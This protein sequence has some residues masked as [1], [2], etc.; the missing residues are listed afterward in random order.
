M[1]FL[2]VMLGVFIG[3]GAVAAVQGVMAIK[4]RRRIRPNVFERPLMDVVDPKNED[5]MS[6]LLGRIRL[7]YGFFFIVLGL[8]A[9]TA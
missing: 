2:T 4:G 9:M 1:P 8:W 7:A 5:E 6:R 3:M